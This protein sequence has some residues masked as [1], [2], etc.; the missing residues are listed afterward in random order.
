MAGCTFDLLVQAPQGIRGVPIMVEGLSLPVPFCMTGVATR[1]ESSFMRVVF[2]MAGDAGPWSLEFC[3]GLEVARFACGLFVSAFQAVFGV[4]VMVEGCSFPAFIGMAPGASG[5]KHPAMIVVFFMTRITGPWSVFEALLGVTRLTFDRG[6]LAS[7]RETGCAVIEGD[8]LP[9][10][11]AMAIRTV[12]SQL[13]LMD[14]IFF[15]TG[16]TA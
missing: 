5:A 9:T 10:F 13:A 3:D 15:M 4:P 12:F 11:V 1:S 7:Q 6:M 16:I 8:R 2:A 14:V